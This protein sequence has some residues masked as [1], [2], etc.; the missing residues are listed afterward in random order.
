MMARYMLASR[1]CLSV[2]C[3]SVCQKSAFYQF[4]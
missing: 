2:V 3:P 4:S 1:V